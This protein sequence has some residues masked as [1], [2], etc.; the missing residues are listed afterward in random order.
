MALPS[1]A[2]KGEE[3]AQKLADAAGEA[4]V[5][6]L[7]SAA[8]KERLD[9][10]NDLRERAPGICTAAQAPGGADAVVFGVA[11]VPGWGEKH[12]QVLGKAFELCGEVAGIPDS[13]FGKVGR[14]AC[15]LA[16]FHSSLL[17]PPAPLVLLEEPLRHPVLLL[18]QVQVIS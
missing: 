14:E 12:F 15:L 18:I 6:A 7:R 1:S 11:A 16:T 17:Y 4:T 5:S 13:G 9:A 2:P 8:W 10:V 3:A